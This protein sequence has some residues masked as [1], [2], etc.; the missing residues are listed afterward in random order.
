MARILLSLIL[1]LALAACGSSFALAQT[2]DDDPCATE[3]AETAQVDDD[4]LFDDEDEWVDDEAD[5][6]DEDE[7]TDEDDE[8]FEDEFEACDDLDEDEDQADDGSD[9][10][11][12]RTSGGRTRRGGRGP[13]RFIGDPAVNR[14]Y[15]RGGN[16]YLDGAGGHDILDGGP[17]GDTI[18]TG[19]RKAGANRKRASKKG[20][21]V[22]AGKGNDVVRARNGHVDTIHCGKGRDSVLADRGDHVRTNNCE[23]VRYG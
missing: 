10:G 13:D 22:T 16:D 23:T 20:A 8:E 9:S 17:G 15:G 19:K 3:V 6:S 11:K 1:A 12:P 18:L 14:F 5:W 21:Q 4:E 7:F 2:E